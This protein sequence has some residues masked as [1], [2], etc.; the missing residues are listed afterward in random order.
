VVVSNLAGVA[1]SAPPA[2]LTVEEPVPLHIAA[3]SLRTV[4]GQFQFAFTAQPGVAVQIEASANLSNWISL[5][6]LTNVTVADPQAPNC[7]RN[8]GTLN[9]GQSTSYQ[10]TVTNVQNSFVNVAT[11]TGTPPAFGSWN[12]KDMLLSEPSPTSPTDEGTYR[13]TFGNTTTAN[14]T[15]DGFRRPTEIAHKTSGSSEFA[16]FD[17]G[18]DASP[19]PPV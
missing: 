10:C 12:S 11:G 15:F 6:T 13:G 2:V 1:T 18:W 19:E 16:G 8:V 14:Y 4:S 17:Y 7:A 9:P 5:I 3:P